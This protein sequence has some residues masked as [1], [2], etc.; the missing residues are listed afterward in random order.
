MD[1]LRRVI[2][3]ND[4]KGRS[5]VITDGEVPAEALAVAAE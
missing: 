1:L 5:M 2:T 3:G 4:A